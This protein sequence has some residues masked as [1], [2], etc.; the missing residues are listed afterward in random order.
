MNNPLLDGALLNFWRNC[1]HICFDI[2]RACQRRCI[3]FLL[4]LLK[5]LSF[6]CVGFIIFNNENVMLCSACVPSPHTHR[7]HLLLLILIIHKVSP[8]FSQSR[9]REVL[10]DVTKHKNIKPSSTL[11]CLLGKH[12][13]ADI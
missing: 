1:K 6:V 2:I 10:Q 3:V 8:V 5:M 12:F 4:L 11:N 9:S 13:K 7:P